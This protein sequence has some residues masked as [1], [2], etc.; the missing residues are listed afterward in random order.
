MRCAASS[1]WERGI[2]CR[3]ICSMTQHYTPEEFLAS[4]ERRE[5]NSVKQVVE[6]TTASPRA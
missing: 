4:Q 5:P 2:Y 3:L 6:W 1:R